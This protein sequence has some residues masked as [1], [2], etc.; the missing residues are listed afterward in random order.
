[1]ANQRPKESHTNQPHT[2]CAAKDDGQQQQE[3]SVGCNEN[4]HIPKQLTLLHS[5]RPKLYC[6]LGVLNTIGLNKIIL[7]QFEL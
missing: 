2:L 3:R 4:K 7:N 6:V 5:E 1:M